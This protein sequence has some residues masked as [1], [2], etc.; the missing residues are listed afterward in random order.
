LDES[1]AQMSKN[2]MRHEKCSQGIT[3]DGLE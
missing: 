3:F 2:L 1:E